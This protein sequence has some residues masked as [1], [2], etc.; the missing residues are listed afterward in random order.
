M[1][2]FV[3]ADVART[4]DLELR[5]PAPAL[6]LDWRGELD[7][8]AQGED[9]PAVARIDALEP[10]HVAKERPGR[11]ASSA[12]MMVCA[13]AITPRSVMLAPC[14]KWPLPFV[15]GMRR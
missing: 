14:P 12:K 8:L 10:Q 6:V 4:R 11:S 13:P 15:L 1:A 3:K 9:R 5:D 2:G 7:A